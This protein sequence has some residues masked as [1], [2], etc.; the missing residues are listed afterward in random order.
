MPVRRLLPQHPAAE[1]SAVQPAG[2]ALR[3]ASV[4]VSRS[5]AAD[6]GAAPHAAGCATCS[7]CYCCV[8]EDEEDVSLGLKTGPSSFK[9]FLKSAR[10]ST[11]AQQLHCETDK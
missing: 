11:G 7:G 8:E 6:A 10:Y 4:A 5:G 9:K 2:A 1:L 3:G